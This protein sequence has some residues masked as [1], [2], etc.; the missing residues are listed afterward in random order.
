VGHRPFAPA[1]LGMQQ[2]IDK[3][4]GASEPIAG[5]LN[6]TWYSRIFQC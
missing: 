1:A 4:V 6:Y 5:I 2:V 3:A